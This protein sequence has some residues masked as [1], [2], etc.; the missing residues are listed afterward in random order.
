MANIKSAKKRVKQT[1]VRT[2]RNRADRSKLRTFLRKI[3]QAIT[4]GNK[5]NATA[6]FKDAQPVLHL[7]AA[8]GLLHKNTIGRKLSRLNARIKALS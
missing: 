1:E 4:G 5:D 8:K 3:E 2:E 6:V 7:S